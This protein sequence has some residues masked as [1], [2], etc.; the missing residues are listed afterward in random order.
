MLAFNSSTL[1]ASDA[2]SPLGAPLSP[3]ILSSLLP[4]ITPSTKHI[5]QYRAHPHVS[6]LVHS[7]HQRHLASIG[8]RS[9]Y[10]RPSTTTAAKNTTPEK[11]APPPPI[12]TTAKS[13]GMQHLA[14]QHPYTTLSRHN[15]PPTNI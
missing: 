13:H 2:P 8:A 12:P 10:V 9:N 5:S 3:F 6:A 7:S 1:G 4:S 11:A 14:T 15:E